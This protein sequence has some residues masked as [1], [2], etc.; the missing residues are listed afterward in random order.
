MRKAIIAGVIVGVFGLLVLLGGT[1]SANDLTVPLPEVRYGEPGSTDDVSV[2]EVP[3]DL[4]ERDCE[5]RLSGKNNA[6]VHEGN[7]L[8]VSSGG[9][10]LWFPGIEDEPD[11]ETVTGGTL[12]LGETVVVALQFGPDGVSSGGF[13]VLFDCEPPTTTST[14]PTTLPDTT[15]TTLPPSTPETSVPVT[16]PDYSG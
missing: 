2:T 13:S 9:Q 8:M 14:V 12:R 10:I 4:L 15:T 11:Q 1:A 3:D 6:S 7:G 16:V 5:V